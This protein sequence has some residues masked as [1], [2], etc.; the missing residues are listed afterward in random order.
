MGN[1]RL[2]GME[3]TALDY[4][5]M[6]GRVSHAIAAELVRRGIIPAGAGL[7]PAVARATIAAMREPLLEELTAIHG[8]PALAELTAFIDEALTPPQGEP[9]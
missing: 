8:T 5:E 9:Q 6:V 4:S 1:V 3:N 7:A 2:Y